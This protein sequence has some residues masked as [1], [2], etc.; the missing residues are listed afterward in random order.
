M[1]ISHETWQHAL[2]LNGD[3]HWV[4]K[5]LRSRTRP[6]TVQTRAEERSRPKDVLTI[7]NAL[8][9]MGDSNNRL[10][11]RKRF[12]PVIRR[13][14]TLARKPERSLASFCVATDVRQLPL[15]GIECQ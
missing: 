10:R 3:E 15:E 1:R 13:L 14:L 2:S 9:E 4:R 12:A 11:G 7:V 6:W 8:V 5:T